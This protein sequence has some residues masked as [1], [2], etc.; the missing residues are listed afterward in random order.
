LTPDGK[1]IGGPKMAA[2]FIEIDFVNKTAVRRG[3]G[4]YWYAMWGGINLAP[5]GKIYTV[6][7]TAGQP[8]ELE[9]G[10]PEATGSP[11]SETWPMPGLPG[12][13][14]DPRSAYFNKL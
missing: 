2:Y 3:D 12:N 13:V 1:I 14:L 10:I 6:P 7:S 9:D 8:L 11:G 5:N 4:Y